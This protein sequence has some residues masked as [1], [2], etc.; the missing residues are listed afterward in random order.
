MCEKQGTPE[1]VERAGA[2][3][4]G[5][6]GAPQNAETV[7]PKIWPKIWVGCW[8]AYNAGCLH[9]RWIDVTDTDQIWNEVNAMLADS[10]EPDAEEWGIFDYDGFEGAEVSEQASFEHVVE[11]AEFVSEHGELGGKLL[12]HFG[13]EIGEARAA[14]EDYAGA[15]RSLEDFAAELTEQSGVNIPD[16]IAHYVDYAAMGRDME[17]GGDVFT[18]ETGFEETHVFWAR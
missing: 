6:A 14:M 10:P 13:Q 9:G 2:L 7:T 1:P 11:L 8:A 17:L 15:Y 3:P 12:T 18:I 16:C 5:G 4:A